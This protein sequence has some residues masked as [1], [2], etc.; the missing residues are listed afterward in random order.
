MYFCEIN[1]KQQYVQTEVITNFF[2]TKKVNAQETFT[3]NF[4]K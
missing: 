2:T 4:W 1:H 3:N